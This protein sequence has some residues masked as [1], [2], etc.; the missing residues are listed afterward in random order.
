MRPFL[1]RYVVAITIFAFWNNLTRANMQFSEQWLRSYVNPALDSDALSHALTMAGLEV[2][3]LKPVA[4]SFSKVVIAQIISA[5]KHPDADRL[6]VCKVD[7]GTGEPLQIV[8]GAPNARAGL[9][10]P[11][12]LVGAGLPGFNIKQAKV[13]GV[14]SFGMMCSAKE[15]GLVEEGSGL[16]TELRTGPELCRKAAAFFHKAQLLGRTHHAE[17]LDA[18]HLGLLDIET[19]QLGAYQRAWRFETGPGIRCAT[20]DLQR[21]TRAHIDFAHLQAIGIWVLLGTYDLGNHD[22]AE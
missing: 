6:Q 16:S 19:G 17:R 20:D 11:C 5:E 8:C 15:L 1:P 13:R 7:V 18:A 10:A 12:A 14:E 22:F 3:G 21:F 4:A 2:E 9:K